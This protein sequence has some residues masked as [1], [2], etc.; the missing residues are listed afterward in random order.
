MIELNTQQA[1]EFA[2]AI[3]ND[4]SDYIK[5]HQVEYNEFL[6]QEERKVI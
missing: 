6:K 3:I 1:N 4:I 2:F 5:Q